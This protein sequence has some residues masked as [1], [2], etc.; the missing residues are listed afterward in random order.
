MRVEKQAEA[1]SE[2]ALLAIA[3]NLDFILGAFK[4]LE[5]LRQSIF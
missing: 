2:R 1:R 4:N 5:D 3:R